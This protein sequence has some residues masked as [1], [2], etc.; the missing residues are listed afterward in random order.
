MAKQLVAF[1]NPKPNIEAEINAK[2]IPEGSFF[3]LEYNVLQLRFLV[4][5]D[6]TILL[7]TANEA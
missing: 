3:G 4:G 7:G 6:P 1:P 2:A 5:K